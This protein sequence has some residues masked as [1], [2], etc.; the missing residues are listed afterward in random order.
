MYFAPLRLLA[1]LIITLSTLFVISG[2]YDAVSLKDITDKTVIL[3]FA[4]LNVLMF[5]LLADMID[6]RA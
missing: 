2:A 5:A 3:G 6:K 1:P 4:S